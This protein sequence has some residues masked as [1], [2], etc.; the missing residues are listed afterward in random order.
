MP[1][2]RLVPSVYAVYFP[3]AGLLKVGYT[4]WKTYVHNARRT[5]RERFGAADGESIWRRP[6]D[7]RTEAFVQSHL[8]Y[9][10]TQPPS[11]DTRMSEWFWVG[12]QMPFALA[13]RLDNI[14]ATIPE[15]VSEAA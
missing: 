9:Q 15:P 3:S 10:F 13:H 1:E 6:G 7:Q 4:T 12:S 5:G 2:R 8:A 14:L 11:N